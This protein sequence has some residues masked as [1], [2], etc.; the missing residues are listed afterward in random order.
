MQ[1]LPVRDRM[2][3]RKRSKRD[4]MVTIDGVISSREKTL[5]KKMEPTMEMYKGYEDNIYQ[6]SHSTFKMKK[7]KKKALTRDSYPSPPP[8]NGPV[9]LMKSLA[10]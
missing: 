7:K 6:C 10:I 8:K 5:P 4:F 2:P 9:R 1:K 3:L